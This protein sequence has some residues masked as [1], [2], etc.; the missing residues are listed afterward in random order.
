[1]VGRLDREN[2]ERGKLKTGHVSAKCRPKAVRQ[3][4]RFIKY[5]AY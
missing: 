2:F 1:M 3:M 4:R 5:Y